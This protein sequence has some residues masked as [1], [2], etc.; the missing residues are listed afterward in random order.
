MTSSPASFQSC[1]VGWLGAWVSSNSEEPGE[2]PNHVPIENRSRLIEGDAADRSG[3][4]WANAGQLQ[5]RFVALGK[6]T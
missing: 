3:G 6:D 2:H 4:V 5:D 1:P